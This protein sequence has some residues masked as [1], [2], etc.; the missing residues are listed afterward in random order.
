MICGMKSS[1]VP[2]LLA[3]LVAAGLLWLAWQGFHLVRWRV[4]YMAPSFF[5]GVIVGAVG[6]AALTSRR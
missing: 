5:A 2:T 6:V 4:R 3:L 1:A